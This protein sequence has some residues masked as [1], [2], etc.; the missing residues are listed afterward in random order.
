MH[1]KIPYGPYSCILAFIQRYVRSDKYG[2]LEIIT[3]IMW[4]NTILPDRLFLCRSSLISKVRL[5]S[6]FGMDP[7]QNSFDSN[8]N[9]I[10]LLFSIRI[11]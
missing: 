1:T 7:I 6:S 9:K 3:R 8:Q 11:Q 4:Y 10:V 5:P 2:A